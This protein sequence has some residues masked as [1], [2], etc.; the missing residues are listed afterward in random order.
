MS[1]KSLPRKDQ[2]IWYFCSECNSHI[3]TK[4]RD[5]HSEYCSIDS[6]VRPNTFVRDKKLIS[7]QL[8]VKPIT[9]D[10]RAIKSKHLNNLVFLHESVFALCDFVLG[11][12]ILVSSSILANEVPIVRNV[13]PVSNG[14]SSA[15]TT[16]LVCEEGNLIVIHSLNFVLI[17]FI[18]SLV[19][20]KSTWKNI[21]DASITIEKLANNIAPA[22]KITLLPVDT[23]SVDKA[24]W[25][26]LKKVLSLHMKGNIYCSDNIV[27]INFFNKKFSFTI[28]AID[29]HITS[30]QI[31][32]L[33]DLFKSIEIIADKF[34]LITNNTKL[35]LLESDQRVPDEMEHQNK[36]P[37]MNLIGGLDDIVR[38]LQDNMNISFGNIKMGPSFYIPRTVLL[39]GQHG[40]GKTL[41]CDALTESTKALTIKINASD[42]FSKYFGET[43]SNLIAHFSK[44]YKNYPNPSIIVIEELSSICPKETKE[45]SAK[46]VQMAFLNILDEIHVRRDA[47]RLFV[48]AT[49]SN[50]ENVCSAVRRYGRLDVEIEIPVPDPLAREQ[51]LTKQL[52]QTKNNLTIDDIKTIAGNSHGFIAADLSNLIAKAAMHASKSDLTKEPV[53]SLHDIQ[54]AYGHVVPSAMKEVVIKCPNVKWCDIGGQDE[55]KLQLKQAIEWPLL[56]PE[57][58]TRLGITPPRGILMFGPPGCSKTMIAKALATES[59]VNFLSIKGPEL[60]SMWVGESERA[61]RDLFQKARQVAPAIIF[62]DEIDAIGGERSA[63]ASGS[64][65]KERVL[66]QLL[67]EMDGVNAL[68]NVTI[69]AAT[70]RPDLIDKAI[71]RPGR[72]DRIV[73]V[74]LPDTK[75]RMDIFK[76]KLSKMPINLTDSDVD[77]LVK[78]T[79]GYSGAEIHAICQEAALYALEEDLLAAIIE[80]KHFSKALD[81]VRPRTSPELLQLYDDY[82]N[83]K[84]KL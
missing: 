58:F 51:I 74:K 24:I 26:D 9:D 43:E 29:H 57:T 65:V 77:N 33:T 44:A 53:I 23:T 3:F 71:M 25:N 21:S 55:L 31:D 42:V 34:Y 83:E 63:S 19:E 48:L 56:H 38:Q 1:R 32:N 8:S 39:Y 64:S 6:I 14:A 50:I 52:Q 75:T 45:E 4:D 18:F 10:L 70:N 84:L 2:I 78:Q 66:T 16:V 37:K 12:F 67:T 68:T 81:S 59:K 47:S 49:T 13:W 73:Y 20:L 22:D 41:L 36:I 62:F 54:F 7:N 40:C 61:V 35:E 11:D 79:N 27:T 80:W 46:R 15:A 72:L 60:F 28:K 5:N 30:E 76:I 17:Y 82:L 69:V